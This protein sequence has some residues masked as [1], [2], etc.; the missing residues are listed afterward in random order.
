MLSPSLD[1]VDV[2]GML[3]LRAFHGTKASLDI[4]EFGVE[5]ANHFF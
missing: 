2:Q 1:G 5:H 3:V 4:V